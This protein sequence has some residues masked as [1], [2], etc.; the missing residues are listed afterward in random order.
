[1]QNQLLK[2]VLKQPNELSSSDVPR[3]CE[4]RGTTLRAANDPRGPDQRKLQ[5]VQIPVK[6]THRKLDSQ[7]GIAIMGFPGSSRE[8]F[9]GLAE[10]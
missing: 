4:N 2:Y 1:M 5:K 7:G 8:R 6:T 10:Y 9:S 3:R